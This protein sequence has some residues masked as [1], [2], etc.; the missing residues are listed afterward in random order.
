[1]NT[2]QEPKVCALFA[3]VVNWAVANGAERVDLL[4]GIWRS[5]TDEWKVSLNPHRHK[6]DDLMPGEMVLEHKTRFAA[7]ASIRINGGVITGM[8]ENEII[9]HFEA[10]AQ[11]ARAQITGQEDRQC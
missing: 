4:P 1:M 2:E 6:I 11:A 7:L 5:E 10:A 8:P 9:A 3:A